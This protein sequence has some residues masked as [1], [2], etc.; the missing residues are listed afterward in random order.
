MLKGN[1][2][3]AQALILIPK[4]TSAQMDEHRQKGLCYT[5]DYHWSRGHVCTAPML[6]LIT[7]VEDADTAPYQMLPLLKRTRASSFSRNFLRF[8]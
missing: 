4:I 5:C 1:F 8:T 2:N 6:F 7:A 3:P